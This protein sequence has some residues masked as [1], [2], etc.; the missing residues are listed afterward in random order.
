MRAPR[1]LR[2]LTLCPFFFPSKI[3]PR[4][5]SLAARTPAAALTQS[6]FAPTKTSSPT[7][8][9]VLLVTATRQTRPLPLPLLPRF[10]QPKELQSHPPLAAQALP[11]ER[12]LP[13]QQPVAPQSR[14]EPPARP[15][16]V[17]ALPL[18]AAQQARPG[19]RD[20]LLRLAW[21]CWVWQPPVL[22][23]CKGSW[24]LDKILNDK[25][26]EF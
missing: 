12:L 3:A 26:R 4:N 8:P 19:P 24:R 25:R 5:N 6:A 7:S 15:Q 21:S 11:L 13:A 18:Q 16:Q 1:Y 9:A 10:A 20:R 14:P 2:Q 23:S 17:Q 22:R